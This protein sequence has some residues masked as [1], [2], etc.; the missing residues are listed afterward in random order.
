MQLNWLNND[1]HEE[2]LI[3]R[4]E[5]KNTNRNNRRI[6]CEGRW[7]FSLGNEYAA[8]IAATICSPYK[9]SSIFE[10]N[11]NA[12]T[13]THTTQKY[14]VLSGDQKW[15]IDFMRFCDASSD[16][17]VFLCSSAYNDLN[18]TTPNAI[19][20]IFIAADRDNFFSMLAKITISHLPRTIRRFL[21]DRVKTNWF[22]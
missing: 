17:I 14:Y 7:H 10:Y 2:K 6:E 8:T 20:W 9:R 3:L 16:Q 11:L 22:S 13:H 1:K 18:E 4:N 15:N 21:L 5:K 19:S 12:H